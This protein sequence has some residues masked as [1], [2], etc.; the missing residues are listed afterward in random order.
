MRKIHVQTLCHQSTITEIQAQMTDNHEKNV[1]LREENQD[2]AGK[3]KK[4]LEQYE[5][6]EQQLEKL[7]KHREL[8]QQLYE[9]KLQ[10]A[11]AVLK[12]EQERNGREKELVSGSLCTDLLS[13]IAAAVG[14][15]LEGGAR[16]QWEG[17]GTGKS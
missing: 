6:R 17:E 11:A 14:S 8:E 10:Q 5:L 16:T 2:M 15:C 12:E 3:L 4:F 7:V 1:K 13:N 9:A